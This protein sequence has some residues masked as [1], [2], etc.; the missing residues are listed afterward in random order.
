MSIASTRLHCAQDYY[1]YIYIATL[2]V[3]WGCSSLPCYPMYNFGMVQVPGHPVGLLWGLESQCSEAHPPLLHWS[4]E[5]QVLASAHHCLLTVAALRLDLRQRHSTF[6]WPGLPPSKHVSL[7]WLMDQSD[8]WSVIVVGEFN[9]IE[10]PG[11]WGCV[12]SG[13]QPVRA[14][15]GGISRCWMML[16]FVAVTDQFIPIC[17]IGSL[18]ASHG[19]MLLAC[20]IPTLYQDAS[21]IIWAVSYS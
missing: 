6:L 19:V 15:C 17:N 1:Y 20:H 3:R 2:I 8:C 21:S 11:T 12:V 14:G 16:F 4:V 7:L 13:G 18:R 9:F 10:L 5:E